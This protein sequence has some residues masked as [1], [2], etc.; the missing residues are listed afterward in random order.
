MFWK[1]SKILITTLL[2]NYRRSRLQNILDTL[3]TPRFF[4]NRNTLNLNLSKNNP[5]FLPAQKHSLG[6]QD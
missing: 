4:M 6:T 3:K 2:K 5:E 1:I